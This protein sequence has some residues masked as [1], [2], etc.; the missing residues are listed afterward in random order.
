MQHVVLPTLA[1]VFDYDSRPF[2]EPHAMI[3]P[4]GVG[5]SAGMLE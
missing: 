2:C 3:D 4:P 1:V 5:G